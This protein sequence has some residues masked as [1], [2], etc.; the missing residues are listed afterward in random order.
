MATAAIL[1]IEIA[2]GYA[3]V[4]DLDAVAYHGEQ[5]VQRGGALGMDLIVAWGWQHVA[6]A[7]GLQGDHERAAAAR[8]AAE[9][10]APG[11][12]DIEGFLVGGQLFAALAGDELDHA[13]DLAWRMTEILRGSHTAPPAHTRAAWPLLLAYAGRP[14]AAAAI[15]EMEDAGLGVVPGGRAWLGLARA[16]V[17]ART[18]PERA[19][20]LAVEADAQLAHMPMWRSLGRRIVAEAAASKGWPVPGSW[21]TE[22]EVTLRGFGFHRAADACRRLRGD[23]PDRVPP[24]WAQRG[25]TR[26]E[27]DVL[28][29]VVEGCSNRQIAE[30]LYLSVRTVEKHVESLLRKTDTK[31]RTQLANAVANT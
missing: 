12:R 29:L 25:I 2:A 3:G 4:D 9:V 6:A 18:A 10:A 14:E 5:A 22:A 28:I 31:N 24:A 11:N 16:M 8:T 15:D 30:R 26:R 21:M 17:I 27:A 19:A 20:A 7:S 13:L 23:E 1:N